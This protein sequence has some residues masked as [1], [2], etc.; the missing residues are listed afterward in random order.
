MEQ[1]LQNYV[2]IDHNP[3]N[4]RSVKQNYIKVEQKCEITQKIKEKCKNIATF[5][6][7]HEK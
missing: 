5:T 6:E 7:L 2:K 1:N 4:Y 3:Q